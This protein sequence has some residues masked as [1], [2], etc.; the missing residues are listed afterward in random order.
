MLISTAPGGGRNSLLPSRLSNAFGAV[1]VP[2]IIP[3]RS[4]SPL[5]PEIGARRNSGRSVVVGDPDEDEKTEKI[6]KSAPTLCDAPVRVRESRFADPG[7]VLGGKDRLAGSSALHLDERRGQP[8]AA[9]VLP[10]EHTKH[11]VAKGASS[12][13]EFVSSSTARLAAETMACEK[14]E[15]L[16]GTNKATP[17]VIRTAPATMTNTQ[18][19]PP[20]PRS[21]NAQ[22]TGLTPARPASSVDV[23]VMNTQQTSPTILRTPAFSTRAK[24]DAQTSPCFPATSR[25]PRRPHDEPVQRGPSVSSHDTFDSDYV[26]EVKTEAFA[27]IRLLTDEGFRISADLESTPYRDK[28][29]RL[30]QDM[31]G[32]HTTLPPSDTESAQGR[33][34]T[35]R[36][37]SAL[38]GFGVV[39]ERALN[40]SQNS[41]RDEII[42]GGPH[43]DVLSTPGVEIEGDARHDPLFGRG[44]SFPGEEAGNVEHGGFLGIEDRQFSSDTLQSLLMYHDRQI[45]GTA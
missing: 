3:P 28:V 1:F 24:Q 45:V 11:D 2:P 40:M 5:A 34:W 23:V 12:S 32:G 16:Q 21:K 22:T 29:D 9:A 13:A 44:G 41:E 18:H 26:R 25:S 36:N 42:L 31:R 33:M 10:G 30:L 43:V 7:V 20:S 19:R 8:Q 38:G 17:I 4:L 14:R 27:G 6:Q 35:N 15:S 37:H 39:A